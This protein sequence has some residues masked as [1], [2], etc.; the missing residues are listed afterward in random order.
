ML[1]LRPYQQEALTAIEDALAQGITRPLLALPTGTGKTVVF[2]HLVARRPGG[3]LILVH[4]DEL[5][6][7]AYDKLKLIAP[8]LSVGIVQATRDETA[9]P[10]ILASVQTVSRPRRLQRLRPEFATVIVDEAHHSVA[11]SYRRVLSYLGCFAPGGPL[12]LG[13]TA[14]PHRGDAVGLAAVFQAIVY[15]KSLVE[16]IQAGYLCDLHALQ[17]H[18]QAD[19]NQLHL[20]RGDFLD[21][22]LEGLL[23][24]AAAPQHVAHAYLAHGQGRKALLF[25]PTVAVAYAMAETFQQ[26][27]IAAEAVAGGTPLA[28]RRA[29]LRRLKT[30]HTQVVANCAVLTEGFDEPS[31]DCIIIARPTRSQALFTQMVGRGTRCYP[32]KTTCLVLD[33]VG[34]TACQ[35]LASV[36]SLAGLPLAAL[37]AGRS[38]AQT[39]ALVQAGEEARA[40]LTGALLAAA[41]D[42]FQARPRHW[43]RTAEAFVL[44]LGTAGW[45]RLAVTLSAQGAEQWEATVITP[46]GARRVLARGL[47][48]GYAQGI[49][50]DYVRRVGV[51]PLVN[52]QADWRHKAASERQK[53]VLGR[54][55][56]P[57]TPELTAGEAADRISVAKLHA[58]LARAGDQAGSP[59]WSQRSAALGLHGGADTPPQPAQEPQPQRAAAERQRHAAA[60]RQGAVV[61]R[62]RALPP[63]EQAVWR[64]RAVA[65]LRQQGIQ[66]RSLVQ[67]LTMLTVYQLLEQQGEPRPT[68]PPPPAEDEPPGLPALPHAAR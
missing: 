37:K 42:L 46:Q 53:W 51:E 45:L 29:I 19:L 13:V 2:A 26:L 43:L 54:L 67:A 38:V 41:V 48:L 8:T 12:T 32:G 36:A 34:N 58:V 35:G 15:H 7:Q 63:E 62:Y 18:L 65:R 11:A 61:E 60:A 1:T 4:R 52:P 33:L 55:Q 30:G 39:A 21:G 40:E 22:E 6:W 20:Q 31:V 28:E 17:I 5:L 14:T 16:M 9:A 44:S 50:E 10:C 49:A 64:E 3:T 66:R 24:H 47:S 56:V 23:L 25:T 59:A 68:K 27:G 57:L